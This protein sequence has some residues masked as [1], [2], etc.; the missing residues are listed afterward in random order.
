MFPNVFTDILK[1]YE[2]PTIYS[3]KPKYCQILVLPIT[4]Y[5]AN[6]MSQFHL[7]FQICP[8]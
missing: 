5:Q 1:I 7:G 6:S 3:K 8:Y 4:I 2:L